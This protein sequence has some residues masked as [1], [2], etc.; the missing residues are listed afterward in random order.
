MKVKTKED[1]TGNV[2]M[3]S[4]AQPAIRSAAAAMEEAIRRVD[5]LYDAEPGAITMEEFK[6]FATGNCVKMVDSKKK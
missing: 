3:F 4:R 1:D 2:A 5:A 6:L